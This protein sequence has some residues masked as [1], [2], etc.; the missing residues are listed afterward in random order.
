MSEK[1]AYEFLELINNDQNI[2][3]QYVTVDPDTAEELVQFGFKYGYTFTA[4][5]L[6]AALDAYGE[7]NLNQALR[8]KLDD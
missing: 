2:Q 4:D 5:D 8:D 3:T 1:A 6:A 7:T